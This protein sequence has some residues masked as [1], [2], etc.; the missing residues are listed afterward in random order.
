[1]MKK[2]NLKG[3]L[4]S[5]IFVLTGGIVYS[6]D[7]GCKVMMPSLSGTYTGECRKGLAHGQGTASGVDSYTGDFRFGLPQG[8]GVYTWANGSKYEGG[9]SKGVKNGPGKMVT[10][11][12]TYAGIW[13][14]D[15]YIGRETITP[16]KVTHVQNVTRWSF[17][18]TKSTLYGI[19]IRFYQGSVEGGGLIDVNIANSAGEQYRDGGIYGIHQPS[20]PVEIRIRFTA[21]NSFGAS[22]FTGDLVFT[23]NEPGSWDVKVYY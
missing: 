11:D 20:F 18:K 1:M 8:T 22:Q 14:D 23:I 12:S 7:T 2:E 15:A 13:K 19:R 17:F 4:L 9:W 21:L 16:Y 5:C 10:A 3:I 6:Q